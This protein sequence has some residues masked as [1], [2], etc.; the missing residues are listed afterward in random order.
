MS[1]T[2]LTG[3]ATACQE[4]VG[5]VLHALTTRGE[6]RRRHLSEAKS[7]VDTAL[8]DAHSGDEWYLA[9]HLRQGIKD[10]ETRLRDAS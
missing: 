10:M 1:V 5:A 8:R 4:A 3:F 9:D 2:H 7:A 6:E